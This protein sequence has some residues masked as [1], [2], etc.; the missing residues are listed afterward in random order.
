MLILFIQIFGAKHNARRKYSPM[1]S[2]QFRAIKNTKTNQ[3]NN[4][5][6]AI[7]KVCGV[8]TPALPNFK[9]PV[10]PEFLNI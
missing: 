8:N 1:N 7:T 9:L 10:G 5:F 4:E 2:C 6:I 3:N